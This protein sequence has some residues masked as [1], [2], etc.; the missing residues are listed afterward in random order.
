MCNRIKPVTVSREIKDIFIKA[1]FNS[2]KYTAHSL[3]HT[4]ATLALLNGASLQEVQMVLRH[5]DV[6]TT[7]IYSHNINRMD[8]NIELLVGKVIKIPNDNKE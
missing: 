6:S 8:N 7:L 3:R 5:K 2:R 4:F 1:G